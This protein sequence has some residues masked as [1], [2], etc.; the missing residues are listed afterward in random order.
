[1]MVK[2]STTIPLPMYRMTIAA[3]CIKPPTYYERYMPTLIAKRTIQTHED[4]GIA[5]LGT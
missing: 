3:A 2:I 4:S 5:L 1:M